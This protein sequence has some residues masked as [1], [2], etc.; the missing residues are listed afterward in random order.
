MLW[1]PLGPRFIDRRSLLL[2]RARVIPGAQGEA[3]ARPWTKELVRQP[4]ARNGGRSS[5]ACAPGAAE[6]PARAQPL[7]SRAL[8]TPTVRAASQHSPA[9]H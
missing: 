8:I 1:G 4:H 3:G 2:F 9:S 7:A 6:P 5:S